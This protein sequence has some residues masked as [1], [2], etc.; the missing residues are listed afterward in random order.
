MNNKTHP[1]KK[2]TGVQKLYSIC[3]AKWYDPFKR[4]WDKWIVSKAET[5]LS[6]FFKSNL[7]KSKKILELGCGTA[8]NLEKILSSGSKFASYLGLDFSPDMLAIAKN[9]FKDNPQVTF[10]EKDITN[11]KDINEKFDIIICTWV[12][13]HLKSPSTLVNEA[14]NFLNK[15]GKMFLIFFTKPRWYINWW[16]FPFSRFLFKTKYL[17][18]KEINKFNNIKSI[19]HFSANIATTVFI[20]KP[21]LQQCL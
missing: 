1:P 9:K 12:L 8:L 4:M 15:G 11:L 2:K 20:E 13:S 14:Q 19:H 21:F 18:K 16:M 5:E 17:S 10:I 7:D 3:H 6:L